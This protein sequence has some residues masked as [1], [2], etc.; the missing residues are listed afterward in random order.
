[1]GHRLVDMTSFYSPNQLGQLQMLKLPI[2]Q[3]MIVVTVIL[4]HCANKNTYV[5]YQMHTLVTEVGKQCKYMG[6]FFAWKAHIF[7]GLFDQG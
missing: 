6:F 4:N 3:C 7:L 2:D 1:M 5:E